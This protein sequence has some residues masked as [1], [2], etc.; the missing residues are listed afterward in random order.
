LVK[1]TEARIVRKGQ[2]ESDTVYRLSR[3]FVRPERRRDGEERRERRDR[4]GEEFSR[5][6]VR[7][8][9]QSDTTTTKCKQ[10]PLEQ[11]QYY[12]ENSTPPKWLR[13][14]SSKVFQQ[15]NNKTDLTQT[16]TTTTTT[17]SEST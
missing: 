2:T 14:T 13:N 6:P 3:V 11:L 8:S 1:S 10:Q 7:R 17:N 5:R 12:N 16:A 15:L 4:V 9:K